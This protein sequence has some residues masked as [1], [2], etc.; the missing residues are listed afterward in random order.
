LSVSSIIYSTVSKN[1]FDT[2]KITFNSICEL[3]FPTPLTY[4]DKKDDAIKLKIT[5]SMDYTEITEMLYVLYNTVQTNNLDYDVDLKMSK[6]R[7][8]SSSGIDIE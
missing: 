8:Y 2:S 3:N 4:L 7:N 5:K 1:T 6:Q